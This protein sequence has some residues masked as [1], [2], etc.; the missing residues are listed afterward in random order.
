[1]S[2]QTTEESKMQKQSNSASLELG[3][4]G[5]PINTIKHF[6]F[7]SKFDFRR[8]STFL[9]RSFINTAI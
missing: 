3:I 5:S 8:H 1:M 4:S 7:R 6:C 9:I 2:I